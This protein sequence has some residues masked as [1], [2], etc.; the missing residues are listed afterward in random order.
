MAIN[1]G[2]SASYLARTLCVPLFCTMFNSVETEGLWITSIV[3]WNLRPVTS[4]VE[5]TLSFFSLFLLISL[6]APGK[7]FFFGAFS[8]LLHGF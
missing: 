8:L 4:G 5:L 2:S 3:H 7:D 1:G 6:F